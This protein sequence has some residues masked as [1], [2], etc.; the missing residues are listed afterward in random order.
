MTNSPTSGG[1][2]FIVDNS[3]ENWKGLKYLQDWTEIAS[4]F[5]IATGFFEI[6]SLLALDGKWQKLDQIRILMGGQAT[7]RTRQALLEGLRKHICQKLDASL[8]A[9]KE[10]IDKVLNQ[11]VKR[12]RERFPSDFIF[13]IGR[14]EFDNLKSQIVTS[15]WGG[16]RRALPYAFTEQGVAMLSSVLRS[17]RAVQV[18]I[19]IMRAFVQLRQ[20][21]SGHVELTRKLADL[22]RRIESH[23]TAIHSLFEAIRHLTAPPRKPRRE[24]GF[25]AIKP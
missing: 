18:N 8:E 22:E 24:I 23:D 7:A 11:A 3:D 14:T 20:L 5:D 2:I 12:N 17:R 15:S 16:A 1:E 4:A 6:G 10:T 19:A 13:Q 21:L 9:E 25:H